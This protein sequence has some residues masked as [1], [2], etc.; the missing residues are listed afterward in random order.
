MENMNGR[1]KRQGQE[2]PDRETV[3]ESRRKARDCELMKYYCHKKAA[4]SLNDLKRYLLHSTLSKQPG[5]SG[6]EQT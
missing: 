4:V 1:T 6:D 2:E 5:R 3:A